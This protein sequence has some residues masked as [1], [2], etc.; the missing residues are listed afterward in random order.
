MNS[1]VTIF[2]AFG[3]AY[4][5][6]DSDIAEPI[7]KRL[8]PEAHCYFCV[9]FWAGLLLELAMAVTSS[10]SYP[11]QMESPAVTVMKCVIVGLASCGVSG[12]LAT[13]LPVYEE[14]E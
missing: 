4:V 12:W 9:G 1:L 8:W 13:Q 14:E 7:R 11:Q 2:A 5:I 6:I 10:L 3:L